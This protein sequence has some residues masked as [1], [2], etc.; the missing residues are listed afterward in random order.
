MQTDI[1]SVAVFGGFRRTEFDAR[2][3]EWARSLYIAEDLDA[4]DSV[5]LMF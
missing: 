3:L 4:A 5:S 1:D 2:A